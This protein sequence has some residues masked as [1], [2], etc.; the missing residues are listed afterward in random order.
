M[1]WQRSHK[2]LAVVGVLLALLAYDVYR[3]D[4][5]RVDEVLVLPDR[6]DEEALDF[7]EMEIPEEENAPSG[8]S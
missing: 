1:S 4:Q 6:E 3:R 8:Q 5:K 7:S 2:I